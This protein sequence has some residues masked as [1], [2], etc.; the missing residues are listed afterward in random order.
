MALSA[1]EPET[2]GTDFP[3]KRRQI[4]EGAAI[5]F[6]ESGYDGASMSRIAERAGVSKGTLYNY[7]ASKSDLFAAFVETEARVKRAWIFGQS[8]D[9]EARD[10]EEDIETALRGIARRLMQSLLSPGWQMLHRMILSEG[11]KFPHLAEIYYRVGPQR[12]RLEFAE[13]LR[14]RDARGDLAVPDPELAA[15][16]FAALCRSELWLLR[17]LHL[18]PVIEESEIGAVADANVAMFLNTYGRKDA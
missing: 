14:D 12:G 6:T 17:C 5:V 1:P 11:G 10:S 7:F 15:E 2:A 3:P 4:I 18:R 13:W 16:Q 8:D 9:A